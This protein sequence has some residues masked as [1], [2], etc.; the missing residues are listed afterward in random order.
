[1]LEHIYLCVIFNR[2]AHNTAHTHIHK[3]C[4]CKYILC[5]RIAQKTFIFKWHELLKKVVDSHK[6]QETRK[7]VKNMH[8]KQCTLLHWFFFCFIAIYFFTINEYSTRI[9]VWWRASF[10]VL[11][12]DKSIALSSTISDIIATE[13]YAISFVTKHHKKMFTT[14]LL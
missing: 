1:M 8:K 6:K 10:I 9:L 5:T 14:F 3:I 12:W 2:H 4:T 11:E 7:S 13:I